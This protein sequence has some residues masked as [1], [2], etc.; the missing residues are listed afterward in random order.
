[1]ARMRGCLWLTAGL[2][3]A[4]LAG[5]VGFITLTRQTAQPGE[6]G[7]VAGRRDEVVVAARQIE[8]RTLITAEDVELK[9]LPVDA[10]PENAIY[11]LEQA[12]DRI[13]L[14]ELFAGEVILQQRLL[15][16]NV[17]TGDGR[18]ALIVAEDEVLMAFPTGDLMSRSSVLKPGDHIDL[19]FSLDFPV[20]QALDETVPQPGEEEE[21]SRAPGETQEER[22]V[23]FDLLED[24]TVAAIVRGAVAGDADEG[25][26]QALLLTV[27]PQDALILK[28]AKD[29][30][31]I[32]DIV[33]RPPGIEGP[34]DTDP[35]D[36]DYMIFRYGINIYRAR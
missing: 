13:T 36:I 14:T 18:L 25:P 3:V 34:Y 17:V 21:A 23:T 16:P 22:Q 19:L 28:Y 15:D 29:A 32:V 8:V 4:I 31:G 20:E 6:E 26:P 11:D 9:E 33:L 5:A 24:V 27:S 12:I 10:I 35:V 30:G 1:M 2:V 7:E